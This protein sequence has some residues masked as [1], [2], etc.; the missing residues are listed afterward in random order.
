MAVTRT[1]H[2][3]PRV[4]GLVF[5]MLSRGSTVH[6]CEVSLYL[7]RFSSN[8]A[9]TKL[10]ETDGQTGAGGVAIYISTVGHGNNYSVLSDLVQT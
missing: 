7:I 8:G 3:K 10:D 9:D 2:R 1:C 4:I 6:L 5:W